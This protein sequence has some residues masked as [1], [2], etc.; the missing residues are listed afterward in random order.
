M[1]TPTAPAVEGWFSEEPEPHLIGTQC[2]QCDTYYFPK[3]SDFCRNPDCF[4]TDF[5]EVP[6]SRTGKVWSYTKHFYQPPEPYI[7][8]GEFEP[9]TIVGVELET[10]KMMVLGQLAAGADEDALKAGLEMEVVIEKLYHQDGTDYTVW[11][12]KPAAG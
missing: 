1:S 8:D 4:S 3:Q 10:E 2:K 7:V 6:L 12:W 9:Y 5:A 11:K